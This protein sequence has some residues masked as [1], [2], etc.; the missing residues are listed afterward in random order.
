MA[1]PHDLSPIRDL[2]GLGEPGS[3][4]RSRRTRA[5]STDSSSVLRILQD[6]RERDLHG[7]G[8]APPLDLVGR[9]LE[10]EQSLHG[11]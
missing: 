4:H 1:S 7:G 6:A 10:P 2:P 9:K 11:E 3:P 8:S 5:R